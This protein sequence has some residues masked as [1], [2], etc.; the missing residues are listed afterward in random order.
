M[1]PERLIYS[2]T[3]KE[4]GEE[5][6]TLGMPAYASKQIF[7]WLYAK[8]VFDP[9]DFSDISKKNRDNLADRFRFI[10][11]SPARKAADEADGT[12][13]IVLLKE[14]KAFFEAVIM[15]SGEHHTACLSTQ[16]GC[17]MRCSFCATAR[18]RKL[19]N[20]SE[21]DMVIQVLSLF[22]ETGIMPQNLV[23]MGM[24][25]PFLNYNALE[26]A[27]E[28]FVSR[29]GFAYSQRH[30]TVSTVGVLEGIKA[31]TARFPKIGI[32]VSLNFTGPG[33][34][35]YMP[36]E[37]SYPVSEVL[38][39]YSR[40]PGLRRPTFEYVLIKDLNDKEADARALLKILG[41]L[42]CKLNVIPYNEN[43]GLP[44]N[45]PDEETL[46]RFLKIVYKGI[47]AVTVR[48]SMGKNISGGCG[49]LSGEMN[50]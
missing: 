8:R 41:G 29:N 5:L 34:A 20:L 36:S 19:V 33:R 18:S 22:R 42:R 23:F 24:G 7:S 32:A 15:R 37:K 4:L 16:T 12:V 2:Y 27:V 44:F 21:A 46:E 3:E 14:E 38:E 40:N 49:Q 17:A 9:A 45:S 30:I 31:L 10:L 6:K 47:N 35:E 48:R 11:P 25:E 43:P 13:K 26:R 50:A 1:P 39:F 28:I